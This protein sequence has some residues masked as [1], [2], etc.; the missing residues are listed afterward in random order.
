MQ[1]NSVWDVEWRGAVG[2]GF[3]EEGLW[4]IPQVVA[5]LGKRSET[6]AGEAGTSFAAWRLLLFPLCPSF[7]SLLVLPTP[8][9]ISPHL[10][11]S[12]PMQW[13]GS[14]IGP[15]G[16]GWPRGSSKCQRHSQ[17]RWGLREG[18]LT[19]ICLFPP[20]AVCQILPKGVVS[21]LGPSSSPASAST[22][23]HI[24]GEKEVS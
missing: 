24:C 9:A 18:P 10:S 3:G 6:E 22:V 2:C 1:E 17:P 12:C 19:A 20:L 23:S 4:D 8:L 21:V 13:V 15:L 14:G 7:V 11:L 5:W 16:L